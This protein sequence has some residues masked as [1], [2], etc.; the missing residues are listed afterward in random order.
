MCHVFMHTY[1]ERIIQNT[2]PVKVILA[3]QLHIYVPPKRKAIQSTL[4][5]GIST[6]EYHYHLCMHTLTN[7]L[8]KYDVI[9][10]ID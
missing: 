4:V 5:S 3:I 8:T 2:Y 6:N 10:K 7:T 1:S 9:D